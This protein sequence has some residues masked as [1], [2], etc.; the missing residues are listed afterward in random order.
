MKASFDGRQIRGPAQTPAATGKTP[1]SVSSNNAGIL[2]RSANCACGGGCP[3]CQNKSDAINISQPTDAAEI[4]ADHIADKVMQTPAGEISAVESSKKSPGAI[5]RECSTCEDEEE[6]IQRKPVSSASDV[7]SQSPAHVS[8]AVSSGGR[9]LDNETRDF[10]EPRMGRDFGNVRIYNNSQ[11]HQFAAAIDAKA[12]T[13]GNDIVFAEGQYRPES[14]NGKQLL[15]HELAHVGQ[16]DMG[17]VNKQTF[18]RQPAERNSRQAQKNNG[19]DAPLKPFVQS[20]LVR[21]I[22]R[23]ADVWRLTID[24]FSN[25]DSVKRM[26]WPTTVPAGV[27]VELEVAITDPIERGW[28][29]LSGV[30]HDTLKFMDPS[31][32]KLFTDHGLKQEFTPEQI[33]EGQMAYYQ[34]TR[35]SQLDAAQARVNDEIPQ[36]SADQIYKEIGSDVL[37]QAS[38]NPGAWPQKGADDHHL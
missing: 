1:A 2:F 6:I 16:A 37:Y 18:F 36:L 19:S 12:Y 38:I 33:R 29:V 4:E 3:A 35:Q 15:A 17:K 14:D 34:S 32:A 9:P 21:E 24:G 26:I 8:N 7:P 13:F 11:A 10:F 23:E 28:F 22:K 31:F 5:Q 20:D 27:Q 30:T 25:P